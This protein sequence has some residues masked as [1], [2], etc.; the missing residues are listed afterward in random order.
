MSKSEGRGSNTKE[1]LK[2]F[3][4]VIQKPVNIPTANTL[5]PPMQPMASPLIQAPKLV[6]AYELYKNRVQQKGRAPILSEEEYFNA[7][8]EYGVDESIAKKASHILATS[9]PLLIGTSGKLASGKD[10]ITDAVINKLGG[11]EYYHLSLSRPLKDEAQEVLEDIRSSKSRQE[12]IKK[13]IA[14]NVGR[15][16]AFDI[17]NL[18]YFGAKTQPDITTRDRT[19][20]IRSMLQYW[21]VEV[22]RAQDESYWLNKAILNAAEE[23]SKGKNIIITDIRFPDEVERLQTIGFTVVRL[24]ITPETQIARLRGRDGLEI[25]PDALAHATEVS[26]DDFKGFNIRVNNDEITLDE[27]VDNIVDEFK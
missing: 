20:W 17:V 6:K 21:G 8:V 9:P 7:L 5:N 18:A 15:Q 23:I 26:L 22:R 2:G 3:Q 11:G 25:D 13:I 27:V 10:T 4:K 19:N 16:E 14:R 12:A 24:D 1:G